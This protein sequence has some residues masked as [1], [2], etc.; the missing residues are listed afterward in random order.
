M[1][2]R[3]QEVTRQL[4]SPKDSDDEVDSTVS[5][6]LGALPKQQQLTLVQLSVFTSGFD[7]DGAAAVMG[8]ETYRARGIIQVRPCLLYLPSDV[9]CA[10]LESWLSARN[11]EL[12]MW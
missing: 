10:W 9:P 4:R 7:E 8:M 1:P 5:V 12:M 2:V 11:L 3:F 6:M